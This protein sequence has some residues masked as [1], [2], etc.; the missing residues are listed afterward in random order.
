MPTHT[1]PIVGL[2]H[3]QPASL[4]V[5]CLGI[6]T[7]LFLLAEPD[8]QFDPNAVAVYLES[9]N[10]PQAAHEKLEHEAPRFGQS[11]DSILGQDQW[12]LGY[13]PRAMAQV[14]RETDTVVPNVP[15][16]VTFET[17]PEGKPRV[18]RDEPFPI[19]IN[20]RGG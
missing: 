9:H 18:R 20:S 4:L 8:N 10:I 12:M 16:D 3:H 2:F 14:L 5:E 11:L 15:V 17:N 19:D 13:I 6:G 1:L 7:L